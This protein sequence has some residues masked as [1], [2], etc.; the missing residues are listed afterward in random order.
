MG[1]MRP[2]LRYPLAQ[3]GQWQK[4]NHPSHQ[5]MSPP[6]QDD[7]D[8]CV[9]VVLSDNRHYATFG[10][11]AASTG[12]LTLLMPALQPTDAGPSATSGLYRDQP[13]THEGSHYTTYLSIMSTV[14]DLS[15][16]DEEL[17]Q[18]VMASVE[19]HL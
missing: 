5:R 15:S 9:E 7:S 14:S 6:Y 1:V 18:A 4:G 17:N 2:P 3:L 13:V 19:T 8:S 10:P 16:D 11:S 12:P